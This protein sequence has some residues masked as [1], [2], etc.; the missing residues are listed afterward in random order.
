MLRSVAASMSTCLAVTIC[1]GIGTSCISC[2]RLCAVTV[3]LP[4]WVMPL[5]GSLADALLAAASCGG[6]SAPKA[7]NGPPSNSRA[8]PPNNS[9]RRLIESGR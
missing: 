7:S 5:A 2:E 1:N 3:I 8:V 4:S 6:A 9:R